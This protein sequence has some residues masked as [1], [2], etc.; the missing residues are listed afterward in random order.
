[1]PYSFQL[2]P[3]LPVLLFSNLTTSTRS[4]L[5]SVILILK[6]QKDYPIFKHLHWF[7]F[8]GRTHYTTSS[9]LLLSS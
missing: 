3:S 7:L 1:M 2:L 8:I 5:D 4:T 6:P 9:F